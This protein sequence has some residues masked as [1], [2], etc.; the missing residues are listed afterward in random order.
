MIGAPATAAKSRTRRS[1]RPAMRGVPRARRA[2]SWAPSATDGRA[3]HARAARD[4]LLQILDRVEVEPDGDAEAVAQRRRQQAGARR[5]ADERELGEVDAHRARGRAL[6]DDE[7]EL[8]VLHR[9][10]E[11]LL[12]RRVQPMDLVDEQHVAFLEVGQQRREVARLGD[13]RARRWRESRRPAPWR[14]SAPAS[15]CRGP[16]G[17]RTARD[18]AP[19]RDRAP[20]G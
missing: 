14:G 19:R 9:R 12:D 2:I 13:D 6:A 17:R 7:I 8:E 3:E 11:D 18:R 16:A 4:D 5:R 1:R 15:S 10:I 20:P